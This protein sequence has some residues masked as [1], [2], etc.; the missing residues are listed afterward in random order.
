M[1]NI[2]W[3]IKTTVHRKYITNFVMSF[4][5]HQ[6][7]DKRFWKSDKSARSIKRKYYE[8]HENTS[9]FVNTEW[10]VSVYHFFTVCHSA[11]I[12]TPTSNSNDDSSTGIS[13]LTQSGHLNC[14]ILSPLCTQSS[15]LVYTKQHTPCI[16]EVP[17]LAILTFAL[18]KNLTASSEIFFVKNYFAFFVFN[19]Q[20]QEKNN[21]MK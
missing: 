5:V 13:R 10:E 9:C 4:C 14:P 20:I 11:V 15:A 3:K 21:D 19:R 12:C 2:K 18:S 16:Y 6:R 8:N 17:I 7:S 1:L